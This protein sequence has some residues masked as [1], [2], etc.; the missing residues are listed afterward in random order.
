VGLVVGID[1]LRR[2]YR[3]LKIIVLLVVIK[4]LFKI[5]ISKRN[6]QRINLLFLIPTI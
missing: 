6:S 4:K 5:H 3:Y 1:T 2:L